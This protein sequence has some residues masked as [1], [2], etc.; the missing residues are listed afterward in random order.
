MRRRVRIELAVGLVVVLGS[1]AGAASRRQECLTA[2]EERIARCV[3][4]CG[5]YA[6]PDSSCRKAVLKHCR[7][8]GVAACPPNPT[9]STSTST[10]HTTTTTTT[11]V[12]AAG[13]S[14][15]APRALTLGATDTGD[16]TSA[17]D[18]A[19]GSCLTNPDT[20]DVVFV[21][22][23]PSD[24]TLVLTLGSDWDSGLHVRTTCDDQGTEVGCVDAQ[25]GGTDEVL[26]IG[27]TGGTTY[28]VFVDA[29]QSDQYGPFSLTSELQ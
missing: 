27:V 29:Y 15:A 23:P 16:T 5:P 21:V 20:Q 26:S 24:G 6:V 13:D 14:C 17:A 19:A 22:T 10:V 8:D 2:C 7:H 28:Y 18:N 1:G 9:T 4:V 11:T 25:G 3:Q 12:P